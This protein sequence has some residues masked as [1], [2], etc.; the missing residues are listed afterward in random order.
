[1]QIVILIINLVVKALLFGEGVSAWEKELME[2]SEE[3][4]AALRSLKGVIGKL[5]N[6]VIYIRKFLNRQQSAWL[7]RP[8]TESAAAPT[9]IP[10]VY[11]SLALL[12]GLRRATVRASKRSELATPPCPLCFLLQKINC[13]MIKAKIECDNVGGGV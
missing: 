12:V 13:L 11:H 4:R 1:V 8:V 10:L 6:F 2:S 7:S 3:Q 9:H 5:H